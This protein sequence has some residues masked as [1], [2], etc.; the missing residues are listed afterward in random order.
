MVKP[1]TYCII[2][3][4]TKEDRKKFR[5][6]NIE[7]LRVHH[8]YYPEAKEIME[9]LEW[10]L[11]SDKKGNMVEENMRGKLFIIVA[12]SCSGDSDDCV[13]VMTEREYSISVK[14]KY[15]FDLYD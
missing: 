6:P 8:G 2:H 5:S 11:Y 13:D 10:K 12:R 15:G 1:M 7:I 14:E 9:D 4:P 3:K